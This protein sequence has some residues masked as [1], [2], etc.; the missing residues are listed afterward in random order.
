MKILITGGA[1]YIGSMLVRK[2]YESDVQFE[3]ITVYDNLMYRQVSLGEFCYRKNFEFV[4][5]DVRHQSE[6]YPHLQSADVII[7]LAAIVGL[8]ACKQDE[9]AATRINF[10]QIKFIVDN[11]SVAQKIIYPNTDSAYGLTDSFCTE[12]TPLMPTSHY[13][14]V[15]TK[16]ETY[17][18]QANRGITLRLATV[19]GV[20][21]RM[22]LDLL[23]NDFT[24][25]ALTDGYI[26]LFEKNFKRNFVHVQDVASAFVFAVKN[27]ESMQNDVFNVGLTSANMTKLEVCQKIKEQ[28]PKFVIQIDEFSNDPDQRNYVVS[29][30]KL[31]SR[32][33]NCNLS[34]ENGIEELMKAYRLIIHSNRKYTNL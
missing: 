25:K 1:G 27:Y 19:F 11:T 20:S 7:P 3:K 8:P 21:S 32:G 15:K 22:R 33:W 5:G 9:E 34:I 2:L 24:Y 6:L 16:S 13:G 28:I 4:K 12:E 14:I 30:A 18:R 29:N 17:L 31:E 26:V 23:V 10:E